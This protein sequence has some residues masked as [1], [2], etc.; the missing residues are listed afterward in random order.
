[1]K[2]LLLILT[3]IISFECSGQKYPQSY[4]N[5]MMRTAVFGSG[6]CACGLKPTNHTHKA[7]VITSASDTAAM[8]TGYSKLETYSLFST[9]Y[10]IEKADTIP[11]IMQVVK[12]WNV[13]LVEW[14][15][16]YILAK[17]SE[18]FPG[19]VGNYIGTFFYKDKSVIKYPV[20]SLI[21]IP[22]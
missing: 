6:N 15:S 10:E 5:E 3:L 2:T 20:I 9:K 4:L 8:P 19:L 14:V 16:G 18:S 21:K 13:P 17:K 22:N 12:N 11:C 1:M 7:G